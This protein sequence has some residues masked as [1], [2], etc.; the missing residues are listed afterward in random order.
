MYDYGSAE[1]N[2]K[3]YGV[4]SGVCWE[5]SGEGGHGISV[6]CTA[7]VCVWREERKGEGGLKCL[8]K[9]SCSPTS[10]TLHTLPPPHPR[11]PT[12]PP[13]MSQN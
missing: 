13:T 3:H 8:F 7:C 4:V 11:S 10:N 1:D 6:L 5:G 12:L 2:M 9:K